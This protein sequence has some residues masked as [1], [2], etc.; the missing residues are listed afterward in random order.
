MGTIKI[1]ES[2]N[3]AVTA[4]KSKPVNYGYTK[5][6][7][8]V[9][10]GLI[11]GI[12][13]AGVMLFNSSSQAAK[14]TFV[15]VQNALISKY[16]A[17]TVT[18]PAHNGAWVVPNATIPNVVLTVNGVDHA[19]TVATGETIVNVTAVCAPELKPEQN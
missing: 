16:G 10:V 1:Q 17:T 14:Q 12:V 18:F 5:R 11:I 4:V 15:D 7:A 3:G 8:A 2:G 9:F 6:D 13:F 19:C